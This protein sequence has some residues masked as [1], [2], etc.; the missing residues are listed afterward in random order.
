MKA[1]VLREF[2]EANKLKVESVPEPRPGYGEVLLR[3]RACGVCYHDVINRRGDLPR[4]RTPAILGHEIAGEVVEVG[5]STIGWRTGDRAATLQRSY[6]GDCIHCRSERLS[7]CKRD[8]RFF[9]EEIPGGYAEYVVAPVGA[10]GHVPT[11][12]DWSA[13]SVT[14]CTTGTAVHVVS[15]RARVAEGET[16]LITG[17]SGG[18]GLQAVQMARV[19]GARVLAVTSSE[20][21]AEALLESGADEVIVSGALDFGGEVKRRTDNKGVDVAIEIVGSKT[22]QE[23]LKA[24]APGG[25][26]V[27]VGNLERG[28]VAINPGLVIVKELSIMGAYATTLEELDEAFRLIEQGLIRPHVAEAL[29]LEDAYAAHDRL[30]KRGVAGRLV[31]MPEA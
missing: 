21:K 30:E 5:P 1:V 23:S 28:T 7:L 22:L 8:A 26:A 12:V 16:V 27:I 9:G 2:G 19:L 3:V 25:R 17:A 11:S 20:A 14:C 4:T 10:L 13:A 31:L 24:L 29:P 18:V 15:T 6:C